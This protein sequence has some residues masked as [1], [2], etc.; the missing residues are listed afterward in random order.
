MKRLPA[1][2]KHYH[3]MVIEDTR[4][5]GYAWLVASHNW[6][7]GR[8]PKRG[9]PF[10]FKED[11]VRQAKIILDSPTGVSFYLS[12]FITDVPRHL[13]GLVS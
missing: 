9:I 2:H 4:P 5:N 7:H 1:V 13:Q 10:D 6:N 8:G 3:L 11:A 12:T